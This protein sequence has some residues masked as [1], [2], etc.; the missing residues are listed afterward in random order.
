MGKAKRLR[1]ERETAAASSS[2]SYSPNARS[3]E[4][5]LARAQE[6]LHEVEQQVSGWI[7]AC[8]KTLREEPDPEEARY[9]CA[10]IDAP[11]VDCDLL[12]LLVGDCLQ[13]L[14][15]ALDH[16]ALEL[17]TAFTVPMTDEI[18]EDSEFPILSDVDRHGT[19]GKGPGKWRD[20]AQSRVRGLAPLAQAEIKRLQPYNR[21]QLFAD[22]PL[23]RLNLLNNIDKHRLLHTVG[24]VMPGAILP[25]SGWRNIA[26]LGH[27]T[28]RIFSD[29]EAE[30]H[31]RVARW[32]A[33]PIDPSKQMH[34][35]FCPVLDVSFHADTALVGGR[36]V[37]ETLRELQAHVL[38]RVLPP[39]VGFL[40]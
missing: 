6:H 33:D 28:I 34:V 30:G 3:F 18:E 10:W 13:C 7:D 40:K 21:G 31:T 23:W 25:N 16:L 39:L 20:S 1:A 11:C 17:A 14:R 29:I 9:H 35:G 15:S 4:L 19:F 12:S 26:A 27:G 5:K 38:A 2:R 37:L 24:T 22:D 36:P 32:P 8:L